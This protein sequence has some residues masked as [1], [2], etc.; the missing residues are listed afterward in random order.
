MDFTVRMAARM[1]RAFDFSPLE[2]EA[3]CGGRG[4]TGKL[5]GIPGGGMSNCKLN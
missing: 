2:I 5:A 4:S 1:S 3:N